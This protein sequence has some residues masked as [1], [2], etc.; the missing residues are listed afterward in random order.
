[1]T[2]FYKTPK[3]QL[4]NPKISSAAVIARYWSSRV[5]SLWLLSRWSSRP[6]FF[7]LPFSSMSRQLTHSFFFQEHPWPAVRHW[8]CKTM[9]VDCSIWMMDC[10]RMDSWIFLA[11]PIYF[12]KQIFTVTIFIVCF[13]EVYTRPRPYQPLLRQYGCYSTIIYIVKWNLSGITIFHLK[14]MMKS[15]LKFL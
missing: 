12:D 6:I 5:Q 1:M 8:D 15:G 11:N 3:V 7:L 10:C 4:L 13:Q 14:M 9:L 2:S